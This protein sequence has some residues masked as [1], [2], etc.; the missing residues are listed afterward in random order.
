M[1]TPSSR[2]F[3]TQQRRCSRGLLHGTSI[4]GRDQGKLSWRGQ[5]GFH[6][7]PTR[8]MPTQGHS[9]SEP[10]LSP[11]SFYPGSYLLCALLVSQLCLNDFTVRSLRG[12]HLCL[13]H[14]TFTSSRGKAVLRLPLCPAC[15]AWSL[16]QVDT[17]ACL[18][19]GSLICCEPGW[20]R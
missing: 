14:Y 17:S 11:P 13:H 7:P 10:F 18:I 12:S 1:F 20:V 6:S 8:A 2:S 16:V 3:Q 9:H 4:Y 19:N 5:G 15:P